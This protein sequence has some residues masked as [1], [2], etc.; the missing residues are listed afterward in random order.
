VFEVCSAWNAGIVV[1]SELFAITLS[2]C[3]ISSG[4]RKFMIK[5][6]VSSKILYSPESLKQLT[7]NRPTIVQDGT[8]LACPSIK[9]SKQARSYTSGL[10]DHGDAREQ[11]NF[12]KEK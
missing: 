7:K 6:F 12:V 5:A 8:R 10:S 11:R 4:F 2:C 1:L 3:A 9:Q